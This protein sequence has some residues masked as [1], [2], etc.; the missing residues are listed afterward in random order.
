MEK[1]KVSSTTLT[2]PAYGT[3]IKA[4]GQ[5]CNLTQ[6]GLMWNAMMRMEV[7]PTMIMLRCRVESLVMS[8]WTRHKRDRRR[9][10]H[11][12]P[13]PTASL[14]VQNELYCRLGGWC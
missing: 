7:Q 10:R 1:A 3:M 4:H 12:G 9:S 2:A 14:A 6:V 8:G 5:A 13:S 11:S